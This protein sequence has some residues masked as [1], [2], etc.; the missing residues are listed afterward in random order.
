MSQ[1]VVRAVK[2]L[3]AISSWSIGKLC[4]ALKAGRSVSVLVSTHC[5]RP[6]AVAT[7]SGVTGTELT[8]TKHRA[9]VLPHL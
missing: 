7:R 2:L 1:A 6:D 4:A 3:Q 8:K 9:A 5:A